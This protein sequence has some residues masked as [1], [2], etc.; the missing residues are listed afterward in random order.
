MV[1]S[2]FIAR[3]VLGG[4]PLQST[5]V[6][7]ILMLVV[8][9]EPRA[10]GADVDQSV[11]CWEKTSTRRPVEWQAPLHFEHIVRATY[12]CGVGHCFAW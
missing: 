3:V 4:T 8:L 1:Y 12:T 10:G 9:S 7:R 2:H 6:T 5:G 11:A